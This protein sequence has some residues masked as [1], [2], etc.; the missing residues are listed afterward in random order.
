MNR[1]NSSDVPLAIR[2]FQ[3]RSLFTISEPYFRAFKRAAPLKRVGPD[4]AGAEQKGFPR[5]LERIA[6]S[7]HPGVKSI[8]DLS[9]PCLSLVIPLK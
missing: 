6:V 3:E 7:I 2:G 5:V 8:P 4:L 9:H 1:S